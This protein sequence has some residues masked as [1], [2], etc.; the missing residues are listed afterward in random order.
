[1]QSNGFY[2][3]LMGL[4]SSNLHMDL[5]QFDSEI[6]DHYTYAR[7]QHRQVYF[8]HLLARF[9]ESPTNSVLCIGLFLSSLNSQYK[10]FP[11]SIET[12]IY[13]SQLFKTSRPNFSLKL[14]LNLKSFTC[15]SLTWICKIPILN[16]TRYF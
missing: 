16:I 9:L 3:I 15:I 8:F 13:Y 12:V 5:K 1:M 10:D 2:H 4:E 14:G 11:S 7:I 6:I